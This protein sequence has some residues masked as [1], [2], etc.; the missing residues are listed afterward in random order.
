MESVLAIAVGFLVACAV[1]LILARDLIRV[2][3]G[4]AISPTPPTC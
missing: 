2:M 4:S 1:F 3:L